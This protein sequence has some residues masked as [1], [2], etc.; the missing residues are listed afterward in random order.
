MKSQTVY[1]SSVTNILKENATS[2]FEGNTT[3]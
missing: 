1:L 2:I 3:Y